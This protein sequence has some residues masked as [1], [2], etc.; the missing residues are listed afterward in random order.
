MNRPLRDPLPPLRVGSPPQE[1][2]TASKASGGGRFG[3]LLLIVMLSLLPLKMASQTPT[4]PISQG[5]SE[6]QFT[7]KTNTEVVLVNVTV[8]DKNGDFIKN[9]NADDF[10]VLE[11]GKKQTIISLD[12][13]NTDGVV[14][15]D[16]PAAPLLT[17][18]IAANKS[19]STAAAAPP[20]RRRTRRERRRRR[21]GCAWPPLVG[22]PV[23]SIARPPREGQAAMS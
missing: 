15:A 17:N 21:T 14:T 20:A 19:P 3:T 23:G 12:E 13:E 8:R 16:S 18:A 7:L 2:E 1:G 22:K 11:D 4:A 5:A 6:G 10:S 9:L